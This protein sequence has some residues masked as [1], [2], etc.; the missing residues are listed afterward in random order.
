VRAVE[1]G[2]V[3]VSAIGLGCWQFGSREWGYGDWYAQH[4]AGAIVQRALDL[5][6]TLLD[7]AEIYGFGR[8]ERIVGEA[9]AG[10]RD[11]AFLATKLL[12]L[13]PVPPVV[14]W[15]ARGSARRLGVDAI[16]LY[17]VHQP[18]P[19]VGDRTTMAGMRRLQAEGLVR[20]VG[21][22]NYSRPRWQT[23]ER[24]LGGPVLS[25]QV[26][27]SLVHRAPEADVLPWANDNDRLVVAYSPLEQGVLGG[28]YGPGDRPRG[29]RATNRHFLPESLER[30]VPLL[31][32]LRRVA[33][34]HGATPAQVSLAWVLA[35]GNVVAIP[36]ASSV[37]QLEHNA[38]AADLDLTPAEVAELT[39]LSDRYRP[40]GPRAM[41]RAR[42]ARR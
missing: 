20:H 8:S 34:A 12:P 40:A 23:A 32:G 42:L 41:V 18:N 30:S 14:T 7:T 33:A 9:L 5:G 2:G 27:Y 29:I 15:R 39:H 4:E 31:D 38:A 28:R 1:V 25:N 19:L 21:V 24:A 35:Q 13:L 17:Q 26:H 22:S 6:V 37:E 3:R 16:D 36:G 10:R 11:E